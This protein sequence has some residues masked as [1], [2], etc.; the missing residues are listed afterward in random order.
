M[1]GDTKADVSRV[2]D[3][4]DA[5]PTGVL[6]LD[7][8]G[9]VEAANDALL[10][11]LEMPEPPRPG[12]GARAFA[13]ALR[14]LLARPEELPESLF[15][16][17]PLQVAA[18]FLLGLND[19]RSLELVASPRLLGGAAG[20]RVLTLRDTTRSVHAV[21]AFRFAEERYRGVVEQ[22]G[23]GIFLFDAETKWVLEANPAITRMLGYS[24]AELRALRIYDFIAH[25][26][27][28]IDRNVERILAEGQLFLGTRRYRRKDGRELTVDVSAS[29]LAYGGRPAL[30]VVARDVTAKLADEAR[31]RLLAH[32]VESSFEMISITDLNDRFTFVNRAFLETYGYTES[33]ILGQH[34][35][36]IDSPRNPIGVREAIFEDTR[37]GRFRGELLNRR[38]DGSE[39][40]I[41]LSTSFVK[42]DEGRVVGLVGIA[43]DIGEKRKAEALQN[44][45]FRIAER[46]S[47]TEDLDEFYAFLHSV[48]GELLYARNFYVALHDEKTGLLHFPYFS[49]EVDEPPPPK[50]LGRGLTEFVLRLGE[51]LLC[52]L[53]LFEVWV[54]QG[55]VELHGAPSV[56]WLGVP[57]QS[58]G[59]TFGVLAL[60]S[61]DEAVRFGERDKEILTFMARHISTAIGRKRGQ[62]ALRE[63]EARFRT[64]SDSTFEGIVVHER[65]RILQ[66][67][68]AFAEMVDLPVAELV[69]RAIESLVA[70]D[71]KESIVERLRN[72]TDEKYE[73]AMLRK[74]GSRFAVEVQAKDI[75]YGDAT[76]RVA[77]V[78]DI[79]DTRRLEDQLRQ[80]QKMEAIGRLAG[81]IAH[82]FN[83]LLTTVLGYSDLI[84]HEL[85]EEDPLAAEIGEIR[86]AAERAAGLTRQLLAFSR[87]Q[88][89][90]PQVLDL[91]GAVANMEKMLRRLIG[92]DV[93]LEVALAPSEPHV[94]ADPGQ[95]EQLVVNLVV[96]ARDAMPDGGTLRI[97]T[98]LCSGA[99]AGLAAESAAT[100]TVSD[101]GVGMDEKTRSRIF[102][103]FFT[104]KEPGKGTGLGLATVYGIVTQAGGQVK[105]A[106]EPGKGSR[107]T[108]ALAEV[109]PPSLEERSARGSGPGRAV[110][111]SGPARRVLLVED[112]ETVRALARRM[113]EERGY[114]VT[115]AR[116]G[117]E[118]LSRAAAEREPFDL[119]ISDLVMPGMSG[120]VL[121][122]RLVRER[123][124]I[125]VLFISGYT[126][127]SVVRKAIAE[128]GVAF[129]QKPF[130]AAALAKK[131]VEAL[132]TRRSL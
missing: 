105:V 58:G 8:L 38:K 60:Q 82:D 103:P 131:V 6:V 81:G 9:R 85:K 89:L 66:A 86:K 19:G 130:T 77:A 5:L 56:D 27:E 120:Q 76:V 129:L 11:M 108:I 30:C 39:F 122:S 97:E 88:I 28:A 92:E 42:D 79:S 4:L 109:A 72:P 37:T 41:F 49:D 91:N 80:A 47:V 22:S 52:P 1:E 59:R 23:D 55:E 94:R 57:L 111:G 114:R 126:E 33:E 121:A 107:F 18:S 63:S 29:A 127:D 17:A 14:S 25:D 116:D 32:T 119:L 24:A 74:D 36:I 125:G 112:E 62:E 53:E 104:T 102:E 90:A 20:G 43:R 26:R 2:R 51:P 15:G 100:L 123:P 98:G 54:R 118:A 48:L 64:L 101:T 96:N 34:V 117:N 21:A 71:E 10:A 95:I 83:N 61:Y 93:A 35:M 3:A 31:S 99:E 68:R 67:N 69:G 75:R 124:G 115:E 65:G 110:V 128:S 50:S 45:L 46:A 113:L 40:P 106:S 12:A 78:R 44:A 70:P 13:E 73:T 16:D 7:A 84:L 132:A 87:K